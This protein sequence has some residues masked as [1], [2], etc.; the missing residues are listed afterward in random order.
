MVWYNNSW[1][2]FLKLLN[3]VSKEREK[4]T[5]KNEPSF[6][7]VIYFVMAHRNYFRR[8]NLRILK[9]ATYTKIEDHYFTCKL[10][11]FLD[12]KGLPN[13]EYF[14]L[15]TQ[16]I[17]FYWFVMKIKKFIL[18]IWWYNRG[19]F[20]LGNKYLGSSLFVMIWNMKDSCQLHCQLTI[21]KLKN[22]AR[23][24]LELIFVN[25]CLMCHWN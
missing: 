17:E 2:G 1:L 10:A 25:S 4:Y 3:Y 20:P 8:N 19:L 9:L 5:A 6:V 18:P 24:L 13:D 12:W 15:S 16:N 22:L 14:I 11:I 23:Q 7:T 21:C